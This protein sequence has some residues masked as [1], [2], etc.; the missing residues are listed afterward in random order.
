[1]KFALTNLLGDPFW[2]IT[3][4]MCL[5][6]WIIALVGSVLDYSTNDNFP[7]FSWWG[8]AFQFLVIVLATYVIIINRIIMYRQALLAMLAVATVY[9]TNST[10]NFVWRDTSQAAA[11]AAG[12]ILLSVVNIIWILYFG[13]NADEPVHSFVLSFAAQKRPPEPGARSRSNHRQADYYEGRRAMQSFPQPPL[14]FSDQL[15]GFEV[16]DTEPATEETNPLDPFGTEPSHQGVSTGVNSNITTQERPA[17]VYSGYSD[18]SN[19]SMAPHYVYKARALFDYT[20]NPEDTNELSFQQNEILEIS[21][22]TGRWWQARR[23]NG[24]VGIA[25]SN[26]VVLLNLST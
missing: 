2:V 9:S 1:M 19:G 16:V 14:Y 10:N 26:Y 20:A 15:R 12:Q 18:R 21:D 6:G 5:V 8:L 23:A 24:E 25:P 13:T 11:T 4:S 3:L 7:I 22:I 17:S